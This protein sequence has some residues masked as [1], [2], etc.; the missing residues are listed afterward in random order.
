E[1]WWTWFSNGVRKLFGGEDRL[2]IQ[3]NFEKINELFQRISLGVDQADPGELE[4]IAAELH[5][6]EKELC[7]FLLTLGK[8]LSLLQDRVAASLDEK[9]K[10]GQ[11]V[12][13]AR[14][15]AINKINIKGTTK[16]VEIAFKDFREHQS[17]N[18][19]KREV[20][21]VVDKVLSGAKVTLDKGQKE[22]AV[23]VLASLPDS[24][25]KAIK[26]PA[27]LQKILRRALPRISE[28]DKP[29][30]RSVLIAFAPPLREGISP[31]VQDVTGTRDF[32]G[33]KR[34]LDGYLEECN[35]ISRTEIQPHDYNEYRKFYFDTKA[36]LPELM[37]RAKGWNLSSADQ[38]W[39]QNTVEMYEYFLDGVAVRLGE[40]EKKTYAESVSVANLP[41]KQI[42]S[43][44]LDAFAS[45]KVPPESKPRNITPLHPEPIAANERATLEAIAAIPELG[46][47]NFQTEVKKCL[48][49]LAAS[50]TK[51]ET[52]L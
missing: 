44:R 19:K 26:N 27:D 15:A 8:H 36:Y 6:E 48:K 14:F 12:D 33:T 43:V 16:N 42:V 47:N 30:L 25:L 39:L 45:E 50:N 20:H 41:S 3:K 37:E 4:A 40:C 24:A 13:P 21:A 35:A 5:V 32:E 34:L 18:L 49:L 28:Q 10:A 1:G 38:E 52:Y 29:I 23:Q 46:D 2:D 17:L 7:P 11:P 51:A 9:Q 22:A 31:R